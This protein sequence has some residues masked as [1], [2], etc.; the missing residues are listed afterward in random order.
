M[1]V[2]PSN[3]QDTHIVISFLI[4]L[5]ACLCVRY[6]STALRVLIVAAVALAVY[7]AIVGFEGLKSV[8]AHP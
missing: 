2:P 5:A 4:V 8:I 7:G 6:W 1:P 3:P